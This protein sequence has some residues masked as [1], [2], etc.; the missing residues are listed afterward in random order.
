MEK[1]KENALMNCTNLDELLDVE[2]GKV[3]TF[4]V[5]SLTQK[6]KHFV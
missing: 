5:K 4:L 3:G 2:F 6:L 1:K